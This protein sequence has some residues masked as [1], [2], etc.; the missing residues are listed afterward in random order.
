MVKFKKRR[1]TDAETPVANT[2]SIHPQP[3]QVLRRR[4][5]I[6]RLEDYK[7]GAL[8]TNKEVNKWLS[9]ALQ[10]PFLSSQHPAVASEGGK[11]ALKD[12]RGWLLAVQQALNEK[13]DDELMQKFIYH[14]RFAMR[15]GRE[16]S[17][18]SGKIRIDD[19]SHFRTIFIGGSGEPLEGGSKDKMM[20][21][22]KREG[23]AMYNLI[24]LS[25]TSPTFRQVLKDSSDWIQKVYAMPPELKDKADDSSR[26]SIKATEAHETGDDYGDEIIKTS[27]LY[28][29]DES[30][31]VEMK[32]EEPEESVTLESTIQDYSSQVESTRQDLGYLE[33]GLPSRQPGY[34]ETLKRQ[35]QQQQKQK[36]TAGKSEFVENISLETVKHFPIVQQQ[37]GKG[38]KT[39]IE[40]FTSRSQFNRA[41]LDELKPLLAEIARDSRIQQSMKDL[42]KIMKRF[43][44][45]MKQKGKKVQLSALMESFPEEWQYDANLKACRKDLKKILE[46]FANKAS[47]N[48]LLNAASALMRESR[49]DYDLR[50][51]FSDCT[52]FLSTCVRDDAYVNREEYYQRGEFLLNRFHD[53]ILAKKYR[54][55]FERLFDEYASFMDNF[56]NDKCT[57]MLLE[58]TRT[59]MTPPSGNILSIFDPTFMKDLKDKIIPSMLS[60][61][62][63]IPL[64][65]IEVV[66]PK[67]HLIL[68]DLVVVTDN[69]V[70]GTIDFHS[71]QRILMK[72]KEK[73]FGIPSTALSLKRRKSRRVRQEEWKTGWKIHLSSMQT[74]LRNV[75]FFY[76]RKQGL[77]K[78]KDSGVADFFIA[79]DRGLDI[80]VEAFTNA[81][82]SLSADQPVSLYPGIVRVK[83][84]RLKLMLHNTKHDKLYRF[85][86][87]FINRSAKRALENAFAVKIR[88]LIA[89]GNVQINWLAKNIMA[90]A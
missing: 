17:K 35:Q 5:I 75:K 78:M 45:E 55:L 39:F 77:F 9:K 85:A 13:N 44:K 54:P 37:Q 34:H 6:Q 49:G 25:L 63:V 53:K 58:K 2:T 42:M 87:P 28:Y 56:S 70:P 21:R 51:F 69:I 23:R 16:E 68:D 29:R 71:S 76:H 1:A 18:R 38:E 88:E 59:L 66:D 52:S 84:D 7:R 47:L 8:P 40:E 81:S 20:Q 50:D 90:T 10:N 26:K 61:Y 31:P 15:M 89:R 32:E 65:R 24:Q 80:E 57:K 43:A 46:R 33:R 79:G 64:P 67:A 86:A 73:I 22:M 11:R 27:R 14:L 4:R 74:E 41:K 62:R 36:K 82:T 3:D 83:I 72:P 48:P 12:V 19:A 60:H 30:K